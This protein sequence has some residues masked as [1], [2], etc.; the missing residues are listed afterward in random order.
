MRLQTGFVPE[1]HIN[2]KS[3]TALINTDQI[4]LLIHQVWIKTHMQ[5]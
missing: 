4:Q 5:E 2:I 3:R 1:G